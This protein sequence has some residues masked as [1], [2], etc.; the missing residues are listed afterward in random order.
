MDTL[1]LRFLLVHLSQKSCHPQCNPCSSPSLHRRRLS[2]LL[3][4]LVHPL[5]ALPRLPSQL[6]VFLRVQILPHLHRAAFTPP[7]CPTLPLVQTKLP[8]QVPHCHRTS[9]TVALPPFILTPPAGQLTPQ[10]LFP[11]PW[12]SRP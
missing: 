6:V 9:P 7:P 8:V 1:P 4:F 12:H 11:P 5:S 10:E 3:L 2:A